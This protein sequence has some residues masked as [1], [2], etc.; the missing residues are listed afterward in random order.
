MF[1]FTVL[2]SL[3]MSLNIL[4]QDLYYLISIFILPF[5]LSGGIISL[6]FFILGDEAGKLYFSSMSGAAAS[7][8]TVVIMLK[9]IGVVNLILVTAAVM[10]IGCFFF[11]KSKKG[12]ISN[13]NLYYSLFVFFI[14]LTVISYSVGLMETPYPD[15]KSSENLLYRETNAMSEISVF[16]SNDNSSLSVLIDNGAMAH[17]MRM[18][19]FDDFKELR[20]TSKTQIVGYS[21]VSNIGHYIVEEK[22]SIHTLVL[23]AGA[24]SDVVSALAYGSDKVTAVEM[25]PLIVD[26]VKED[27]REYSGDL[28][29][30]DDVSVVID[31]GRS[32]VRNSE[33]KYSHI[34]ISMTD[35][36]VPMVK[37]TTLRENYLYTK[38]AVQEYMDSLVNEGILSITHWK[39]M[40]APLQNVIYS[41]IE[42]MGKD[43]E[44]HML[45]VV[46]RH[47]PEA[48]QEG[49]I[50]FLVKES[51][52][53]D[54]EIEK[55]RDFSNKIGLDHVQN[56][57]Y[58]ESLDV[59]TDE[60]PFTFLESEISEV[61]KYLF[62]IL[63]F[64]GFLFL[65]VLYF[66]IIRSEVNMKKNLIFTPYFVFI[67]LGYI[68]VELSLIQKM[69]FFL[70]RPLYSNTIVITSFV[71][72]C[73][74]GALI[75]EKK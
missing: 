35:S 18:E 6:V 19:N 59:A 38:E 61:F 47:L 30:R 24:G 44:D 75:T 34:Q 5:V 36:F 7:G 14:L 58:D 51:P 28:Y 39:A 2:F 17:L 48:T 31:E 71:L 64:I 12:L 72:F 26:L 57:G 4:T 3:F 8:L 70:G 73:G 65:P 55:V 46:D 15:Y 10:F 1:S 27:F 37:T 56:I 50:T 16:S 69:I 66:K 22:P 21:K 23:G 13:K 63:A 9:L 74:F 40:H 54:E 49:V 43:P 53:T 20:N 62:I 32:Y 45:I 52:F 29:H 60:R 67:G 42:D 68:F 11:L 33:S 41:A 25:N